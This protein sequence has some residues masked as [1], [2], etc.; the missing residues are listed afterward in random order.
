MKN[1]TRDEIITIISKMSTTLIKS[2]LE[3]KIYKQAIT[4]FINNEIQN[5]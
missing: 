4:N 5:F 1:Y 2:E 3:N